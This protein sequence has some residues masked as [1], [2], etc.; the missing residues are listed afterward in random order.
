MHST[1][2]ISKSKLLH[3]IYPSVFSFDDKRLLNT[4]KIDKNLSEIFLNSFF[5]FLPTHGYKFRIF[6]KTLAFLVYS[7]EYFFV[8]VF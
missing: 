4:L 7:M 2:P 1:P 5:K 3:V 8:S 6:L